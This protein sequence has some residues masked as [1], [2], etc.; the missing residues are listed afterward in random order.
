M[1][2]EQAADAG[3]GGAGLLAGTE[4]LLIALGFEHGEVES[5]FFL[6]SLHTRC[7]DEQRRDLGVGGQVA[8]RPTKNTTPSSTMPAVSFRPMR[9]VEGSSTNASPGP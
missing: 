4:L 1:E 9:T 5:Q 3:T 7:P 8:G 2:L 6:G